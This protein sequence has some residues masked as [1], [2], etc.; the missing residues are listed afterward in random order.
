MSAPS[1][2]DSCLLPL[3]ELDKPIYRIFPRE[4]FLQALSENCLALVCPSM[5]DDPFEIVDSA[6]PVHWTE[7]G[8]LRRHI[9]HGLP[10][11]FAQSWSATRESDALLRAYSKVRRGTHSNLNTCPDEEGVRVQTTHRKLLQAVLNATTSNGEISCFIGAV[12]YVSSDEVLS[13]FSKAIYKDGL[14]ALNLPKIRAMGLLRKRVAFSSEAE[15]RVMAIHQRT[16][17]SDRLLRVPIHPND[18]IDEVAF[19]PRLADVEMYRRQEEAKAH[20]YAGH[21]HNW[22]LYT[23]VIPVVQMPS[24]WVPR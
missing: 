18:F 24:D 1:I 16:R 19:D 2:D 6:I 8:Q 4:R 7:N 23:R 21:F 11:V 5:W 10:S 13:Y 9:I 12:T 22:E 20:G 17:V 3:A 14:H 15:V